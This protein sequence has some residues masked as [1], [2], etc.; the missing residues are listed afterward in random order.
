MKLSHLLESV[1]SLSGSYDG[2]TWHPIR[3]MTAENTFLPLRIKAAWR[4]L[5]GR[6]DAI[7]W[8]QEEAAKKKSAA[9]STP[10]IEP[11]SIQ[12]QH[13]RIMGKP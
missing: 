5:M 2:V 1:K 3:P 10:P 12:E 4:V 13:D 8:D 11:A 7:E 6:S 9:P